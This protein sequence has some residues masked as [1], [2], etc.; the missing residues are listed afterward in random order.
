MS[1]SAGP[2][3]FKHSVRLP[4]RLPPSLKRFP[5]IDHH[6][7]Y[8]S[9]D[10]GFLNST[11]QDRMARKYHHGMDIVTRP[12]VDLSRGTCRDSTEYSD[13]TCQPLDSRMQ[14]LRR[15]QPRRTP[16]KSALRQS[17]HLSVAIYLRQVLDQPRNWQTAPP[18]GVL[19]DLRWISPLPFRCHCFPAGYAV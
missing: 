9:W 14:N 13:R 11:A 12:L 19:K 1:S 7:R 4:S 6:N 8:Q 18:P 16:T 2:D 3:L 17:A 15:L 10:N 5:Q